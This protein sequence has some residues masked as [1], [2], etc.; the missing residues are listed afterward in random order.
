MEIKNRP[1]GRYL[2]EFEVGDVIETAGRTVTEADIVF[3]AGLSGDYNP[4]HTNEEWAKKTAMGGRIA[5]GIL[6]AAIASGLRMQSRIT[7][8][9]AIALL[10]IKESFL[11]PTKAGDTIHC[12][13]TITEVKPSKSKPDRGIVKYDCDVINQK[14]QLVM[15]QEVS[16]MLRRKPK[17]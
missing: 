14:E 5:H 10:E 9:T 12:K 2:D 3:F 8:G 7:E 15:H 4:L 6:I 17:K 11:A 13:M 16:V 1:A